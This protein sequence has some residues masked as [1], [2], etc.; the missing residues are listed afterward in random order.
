[1]DPS[2]KKIPKSTIVPLS[3]HPYQGIHHRFKS[4]LTKMIKYDTQHWSM[5][6]DNSGHV[7]CEYK[8][9]NLHKG[10]KDRNSRSSFMM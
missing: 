10:I 3:I 7:K 5:N 4:P 8:Y 1:M 6:L 9:V 2:Q